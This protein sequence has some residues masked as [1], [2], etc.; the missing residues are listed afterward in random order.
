METTTSAFL[1]IIPR[2]EIQRKGVEILHEIIV[3]LKSPQDH[4]SSKTNYCNGIL[5]E[6]LVLVILRR[7]LSLIALNNAYWRVLSG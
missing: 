3:R 7:I 2:I 5:M 1:T 6:N 4:R